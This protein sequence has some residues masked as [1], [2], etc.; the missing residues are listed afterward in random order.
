MDAN[1]LQYTAFFGAIRTLENAF[2]E[3]VGSQAA[4]FLEKFAGGA[5]EDA[6]EEIRQV[7]V[8]VWMQWDFVLFFGSAREV[9]FQTIECNERIRIAVNVGMHSASLALHI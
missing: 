8:L 7:S 2:F 6:E 9:A 3:A 4:I 1:K 5:Y